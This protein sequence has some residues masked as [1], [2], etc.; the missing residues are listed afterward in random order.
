MYEVLIVGGG[1]AGLAATMYCLR[2]GID[3]QMV[4]GRLGGKSTL[5]LNLPDMAEYH[6]L[7]AREQVQVFRGRIEYLS[8]IWRKG[9]VDAVKEEQ[10]GFRVSVRS[11]PEGRKGETWKNYPRSGSSWRR[12]PNRAP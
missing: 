9:H 6:V 8:H 10:D 11:I 12:E 1:P 5:S 4:T 7:K 3:V 2:K